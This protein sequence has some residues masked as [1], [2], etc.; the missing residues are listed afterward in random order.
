MLLNVNMRVCYWMFV[1]VCVIECLY[2]CVLLNVCM[3]V[4]YWMLV[5][6]CMCCCS[7]VHMHF[8]LRMYCHTSLHMYTYFRCLLVGSSGTKEET[9]KRE[10]WVRKEEIDFAIRIF[11]SNFSELNVYFYL[12]TK[13]LFCGDVFIVI[14]MMMMIKIKIIITIFGMVFIDR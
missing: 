9:V 5:C 6:V 13:C 14:R 1:C 4:C 10:E 11:P 12:H 2:A 7:C 3:R 8:V